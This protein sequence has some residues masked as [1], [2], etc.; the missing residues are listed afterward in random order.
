MVEGLKS[1]ARSLN[2]NDQKIGSLVNNLANINSTGYK[3]EMPFEQIIDKNGDVKLRNTLLDF[4]QGDMIQTDNPLD[5]AISGEAFF[6]TENLNG[7]LQFTKN[8]KFEISDDGYI[9]DAVGNKLVGEGGAILLQEDFW[10]Q[11]QTISISSEGEIYV[12]K[13]FIDK[14]Q[15]VQIEDKENL[16]RTGN[17]NYMLPDGYFFKAD[18]DSYKVS[19]GY[20]ENSNVNPIIEMEEMIRI[21]KE[22]ESAQKMIQY[23]DEIM[24]RANEIGSIK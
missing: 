2:I 1:A 9:I 15:L 14:L 3:R 17:N 20:L 16:V 12:G 8:G 19:Q 7:E 23:L 24:G 4:K 6:V 18:E 13:N 5:L 22:Y 11:N 21:S 10:Q